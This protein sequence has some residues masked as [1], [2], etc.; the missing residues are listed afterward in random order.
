MARQPGD[1]GRQERERAEAAIVRPLGDAGQ[2]RD[3]GADVLGVVAVGG[4]CQPV[5]IRRGQPEHL[6]ELADRAARAVGGERRDQRRAIAAVARVHGGDQLRAHV[7]REVEVD[8]RGGGHLAVQEAPEREPCRH[9]VDVREPGQVADDRADGRAAPAPGRQHLA[10]GARPAHLD[11]DLPRELE[12]LAVQQEEAGQ[13]VVGD[14]L[15]LLLEARTGGRAVRVV[16]AVARV[17]RMAADARELAVGVVRRRVAVAEVAGQVELAALGHPRRLGHGLGQVGEAAPPSPLALFSTCSR[18]PRRSA[19]QASSGSPQRIATSASC[20]AARRRWWTCTSFVATSVS[21]SVRASSC[22]RAQAGAV[23]A[24]ER[25]RQLDPQPLGPERVAQ[26]AAAR[27]RRLAVLVDE[28]PLAR[29]AG[30]RDQALRVLAQERQRQ[31]R[32]QP[33]GAVRLGDRPA[34]VAVARRRLAQHGH[35]ERPCVI[36]HGQLGAGDRPHPGIACRL[37][38]DERAAQVVVIGQRERLEPELGGPQ[39]ELLGLGGAV[40]ERERRV[41]VQLGVGGVGGAHQSRWRYQPPPRRSSNTTVSRP[42]SST[43]SE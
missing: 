3:L 43:S 36:A 29:A 34:E 32:R 18:L 6:A 40:Q 21:S 38:E 37:G 27:E 4:P 28:R 5:E 9:R 13:P 35:V 17:Q 2:A 23:A 19:S 10:G 11:R 1:L 8:V 16:V 24:Q 33:I 15:E 42:P 39:G 30:E 41:A 26:A 22:R 7:A 31:L 20:S 14:Q 25:A 12:D